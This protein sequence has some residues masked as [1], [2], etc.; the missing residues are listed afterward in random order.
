[1]GAPTSFAAQ[2]G[3][4]IVAVASPPGEG[5]RAI[6]RMSGHRSFAI[7]TSLFSAPDAPGPPPPDGPES[8]TVRMGELSLPGWETTLPAL[9]YLMPAPA[10]Y[11]RED[12]AELHVVGSPPVLL[13]LLEACRGLGAR[14]A[15]PGE[16]TRRALLSGR[17]D[18]SQAEAVLKIIDAHDETEAQAAAAELA[19][20]LGDSLR[21]LADRLF[22]LLTRLEAAIDFSQEGIELINAEEVASALDDAGNQVRHMLS[23]TS[24]QPVLELPTVLLFGR[25]NAG[26]SSLFNRLLGRPAALV[27][28]VPGTT[29]DAVEATLSI[30]GRRLTLVDGAGELEE[31][32]GLDARAAERT[33]SRLAGADL[34][35]SIVDGSRPATDEDR[36]LAALVRDLPH[37][38]VLSKC[39]LSEL[40]EPGVLAELT[41]G[42]PVLRVS[43]K[44][45]DGIAALRDE[46]RSAF[47][48]GRAR[49]GPAHFLLNA[50]QRGALRQA[51]QSLGSARSAL[52]AGLGEEFVA[53]DLW[54]ALEALGELT[55]RRTTEEVLDL[56][57]SRFC[58]G[59]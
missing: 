43:A 24:E 54:S 49:P 33:R 15:A 36:R 11:T 2:L 51:Q 52:E 8:Y 32:D 29:R 55:G 47:A 13:D 34:V 16:F 44:T 21:G 46:L 5:A 57:F 41:G 14:L 28:H 3:D 37:L 19:G 10:S 20:S 39:D 23:Q 30:E 50:R 38:W 27:T 12:V 1:M 6:V 9:A 18:L 40:V 45:G 7:L 48:G 26:K 4:T 25:A 35:V 22:E 17:I 56:I 59:K 31:P 53:A 42:E 58:I